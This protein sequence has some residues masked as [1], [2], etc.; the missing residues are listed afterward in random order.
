MSAPSRHDGDPVRLDAR[1]PED[2]DGR[3]PVTVFSGFLGAGKTTL[4]NHVLANREGRR[5]AVIVN[6][7]SE[8]NI[9][10]Q[11]VANP[12]AAP[13]AS[14]LSRTEEKLVEFS[15]GCICCTL[16]KDLLEEVAKLAREKRFDYLL[17][18]STGISEP[19]P[20]AETFTFVDETGESLSSLARLDTLVTLVDAKNFLDDYC[21]RDELRER[22]IGLDENDSRDLVQLLVEQVE[23]ANVIV[24]NKTDLIDVE[25]LAYLETILRKLNPAARIIRT[26]QGRAPLDALLD[27]HSFDMEHAAGHPGWLAE[28]PGTHIP[29]TEEYGISSRVFQARRP[30]HPQRFW[31]LI[32]GP[33]FRGVIRSKGFVW[34]AT[35]QDWAGVWS[36]AGVVSSLQPAGKWL[37][38]ATREEWPEDLEDSDVAAI[39]MEP[40][41]DR[42]QELVVIGA[43]LT[44][45]L[46]DQFHLCCLTD[47]E[48]ELQP[49]G[50]LAFEDPFPAWR[51]ASSESEEDESEQDESYRSGG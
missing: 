26:A 27:T 28:A 48:M 11:L 46:L 39:W 4:L 8:V 51:I 7:M 1:N 47:A 41:G 18:E 31:D 12:L 3:L 45:S 33:A 9:D 50:W 43:N 17:V 22:G 10:A 30:L 15:N 49:E 35:R 34:L 21:S 37:A 14:R 36:S 20:V 6:D 24:I 19:L 38:S 13:V 42:R 32:T 2:R 40:W 23:F 25:D 29:E 5:V 16:R 44:D